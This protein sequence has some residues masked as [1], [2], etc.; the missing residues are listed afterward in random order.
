MKG[1]GYV[2]ATKMLVQQR[3]PVMFMYREKGST[4]DSG[5]RFFCGKEDQDYCDN[6]NNIATYDIQTILEIDPSIK[7]YLNSI[8]GCAF[9]RADANSCFS[10]AKG[11]DFS[12]P[13]KEG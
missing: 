10:P 3:L 8:E 4:Q 5:W 1:F 9:E 13:D 11:F 6:P 2:L 7:P 12:A